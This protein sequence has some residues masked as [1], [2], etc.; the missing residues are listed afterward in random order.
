MKQL[1]LSIAVITCISAGMLAT[2]YDSLNISEDDARKYLLASIV[3][4]YVVHTDHT[5]LVSD[6]RNLPVEAKVEGTR[7]LMQLAKE[8]TA[9]EEFKK[10]YKK[11][12]NK[13][14]NGDTKSKIGIPNLGKML[15]KAVDNKMDKAKNEKNYPPDAVDMVKKRLND[16][17]EIS[18]TVDF[19][20]EV[21]GGMFVNPEYQK[22]S[23]WWKMCYRA[24]KDVVAAAREEAQ[25]WLD[26]L[27][28][29]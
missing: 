5:S 9:T 26:E 11:A 24:G 3:Q 21:S 4:G 23:S 16:F 6:A 14:L 25:K 22:K 10:D 28:G 18:A 29:K 7:Q 2:I 19:D 8:Y 17:L 1:L 15:D 12:R 13:M 20:A 27:N